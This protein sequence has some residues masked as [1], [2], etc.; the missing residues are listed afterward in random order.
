MLIVPPISNVEDILIN[1][2]R[3][4]EGKK[5][6][7]ICNLKFFRATLLS[8]ESIDITPKNG[9]AFPWAGKDAA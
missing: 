2:T 3:L 4:K 9:K 5:S 6:L 8:K 7:I 1:R